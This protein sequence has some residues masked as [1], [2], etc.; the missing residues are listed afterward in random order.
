TLLGLAAWDGRTVRV[1]PQFEGKMIHA[2][3]EDREGTLWVGTSAGNEGLLCAIRAGATQCH[4]GDG[5]F[6][7]G[8]A[9]LY[10]QADGTLWAASG[11]DRV[12]RLKPAPPKAY[13]VP[14]TIGSLQL[15][16]ETASGAM[17][18]GTLD[19]IRRIA[20]RGAEPYSLPGT[21]RK[22]KVSALLRDQ[23]GG[24]WI[25]TR[26]AGLVHVHGGRTEVITRADGLS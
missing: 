16:S 23:H 5:R 18:V 13:P 21:T 9:S 8:V 17:I 11:A 14:G 22:L 4:G 1:Y 20:E 2:L 24:L 12:W 10:E 3:H 26:D 15:L 7:L 6:S 25:G 19:G